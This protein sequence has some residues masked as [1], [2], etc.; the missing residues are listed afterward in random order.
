MSCPATGLKD[1]PIQ[2][3]VTITETLNQSVFEPSSLE[4]QWGKRGTVPTFQENYFT[5]GIYNSGDQTSTLRIRGSLYTLK[6]VKIAE[7]QHA[8]FLPSEDKRLCLGEI[9]MVFE[10]SASITEKFV[11]ACV[12]I[13]NKSTTSPS[14]YLE[15]IRQDKLPGRPIGLDDLLPSSKKYISY[16][17]C[18]H[19]VTG[20]KTNAVQANVLVFTQGLFY[21]SSLLMELRRKIKSI[22]LPS[23][24]PAGTVPMPPLGS[25]AEGLLAKT[26]PSPF[27][28]TSEIDYKQFVRSSELTTPSSG[29][30]GKRIDSTSSYKCVPLKPDINVKDNRIIIDTDNGVPLS[31][32][33]KEKEED[34]GLGKIT[35]GMVERMIAI[36]LGSAAGLFVLS[37]IA[38]I[39]S[40]VTTENADGNFPWLMAKT[41][42]LLPMFFVS[43]VV[44]IIG[45]LIG[46]FTSTT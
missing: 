33:L 19:Q 30:S 41:K 5:E 44:G 45:F 34:Q 20:G 1:F 37:I 26:N 11:F 7:A 27:L 2:N 42:D 6:F 43:I 9:L 39:F 25:L 13:L 40:R 3:N 36:V 31:Q 24:I 35:P 22:P 16:V 23:P 15:S 18:L 10:S 12:P 29:T 4:F 21:N 28:L 32:V 38:Y 14:A 17:T 8:S 46:F